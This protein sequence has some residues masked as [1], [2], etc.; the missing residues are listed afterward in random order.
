MDMI[1]KRAAGKKVLRTFCCP[2][3]GNIDTIA[4]DRDEP[5]WDD[6]A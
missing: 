3:C 4:Y 1:A 5:F 2:S 6:V